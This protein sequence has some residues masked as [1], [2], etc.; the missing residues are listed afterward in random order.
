MHYF[1]DK[2]MSVVEKVYD[3]FQLWNLIGYQKYYR[4][5]VVNTI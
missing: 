4:A 1:S 2:T 5:S 3:M